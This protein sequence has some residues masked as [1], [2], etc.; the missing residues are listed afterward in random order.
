MEITSKIFQD[1]KFSEVS[2]L[3]WSFWVEIPW[4]NIIWNTFIV[5][6]FLFCS[7]IFFLIQSSILFIFLFCNSVESS[8]GDRSSKFH[9]C[10]N[11]C[12]KGCDL[13]EY[14]GKLPIYLTLFWWDCPDECKY[15]C[16]HNI[17]QSDVRNNRPVKQYYG[18]VRD[19]IERWFCCSALT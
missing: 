13:D 8:R 14:P 16:M 17:T 15:Q 9:H 10:I 4:Y 19:L 12:F 1:F 18:K 7:A 6:F 5:I 2:K 11:T 3:L